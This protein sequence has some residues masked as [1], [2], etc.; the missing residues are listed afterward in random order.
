MRF[1]DE[2]LMAYADG[3]LDA[4]TRATIEAAL[5]TDPEVAA[6]VARHR[7]LREQLRATFDPVLEEQVPDRLATIARTAPTRRETNVIPLRPKAV[8]RWDWAHGGAVAASLV[9]GI[10][11]GQLVH[12]GPDSGPVATRDGLLVA[13]TTLS[14]ALSSQLTSDQP[15][16]APIQIGV[17]FRA[18][19]GG[20]CRS[21]LWRG[22]S[23]LAGLACHDRDGW[24]MEMLMPASAVTGADGG[25][26]QAS[27]AMPRA[28]LQ[29]VDERIEGEPLDA[30]G[31]R[32]ASSHDWHR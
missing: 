6:I 17:S 11:A 8:R 12:R 13:G 31:E 32:E 24:R 22:P 29:A 3:E 28:I 21:F 1:S 30:H 5:A 7:A 26:R 20:F 18:K 16:E 15:R 10:L 19:S 25:Y 4:Q 23:S 9:L 27:S 14:A 2:T